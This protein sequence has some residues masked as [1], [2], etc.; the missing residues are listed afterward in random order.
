M[1]NF[2][3]RLSL[4][5][6]AGTFIVLSSCDKKDDDPGGGGDPPSSNFTAKVDGNDF[7]A[8]QY[9]ASVDEDHNLVIGGLNSQGSTIVLALAN[10]TGE[11]SFNF[12]PNSQSGALYTPDTA[13]FTNL[14][15]TSG[16]NG[17]GSAVVTGW[18]GTDSI[19][20]GTFSFNA[21]HVTNTSTVTVTEGSFSSIQVEFESDGGSG[22]GDNSFSVKIDGTLWE[23]SGSNVFGISTTSILIS[24]MNPANSSSFFLTVPANASVGNHPIDFVNYNIIY[25]PNATD[26]SF[27]A[28]SGSINITQHDQ[29][30]NHIEATFNFEGMSGISTKSFT[31]GELSV[32]Y[33]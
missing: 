12:S 33:Q 1:K 20:S 15:I 31:D 18:N 26:P 9:G 2:L 24:A 13:N 32:D 29:V 17:S 3:I 6:A 10:F 23:Q 30:N 14:Y 25:T 21:Q 16:E 19:I 8:I 22:G 27:I 4:L 5:L 11:G 7:S 28:T